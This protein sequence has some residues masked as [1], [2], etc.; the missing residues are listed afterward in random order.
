MLG[1]LL[2]PTIEELIRE[3][4]F[5]SL[6]EHLSTLQAADIAD[7]IED[8]HES[9][10]TV[11]F[12]LLPKEKATE[13]F[14]YLDRGQQQELLE[15][16]SREQVKGILEEMSVDDRTALLDEVPPEVASQLIELLP[17][18]DR[19]LA[20]TILNYP[21]G[22]VGRLITPDYVALSEEMTVAQ[23]LDRIRKFGKDMETVY[24]CYVI[25]SHRK[26]LGFIS[27]RKLV[28]S[29]LDALIGDLYETNFVH[30]RTDT[31]AEDAVDIFRRY[32]LIALPVLDSE[33]NM[34]GIVTFD[35]IMDVAEEE[36]REDM[37]RMAAVVP[38][39]SDAG[40]L[41]ESLLSLVKR[42]SP[43]LVML[44]A[45]Q[46]VAALILIRF[47]DLLESYTALLFFL[48]AL[49]A[50]GGNTGTQCSSMVI[51]AIATGEVSL[52][53]LKPVLRRAF[54]SGVMLAATLGACGFVISLVIRHDILVSLCVASGLAVVVLLSNMA[55][56]LLPMLFKRLGLD[57]A[58]M[59]G[60]FISTIT[61]IFG[62]FVYLEISRNILRLLG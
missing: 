24:A 11:L 37:D 9:H 51:R 62:L 20:Q 40:F 1:K 44:L 36:F 41:E 15:S 47:E 57:P 10:L 25:G 45:I 56:S 39:E 27:L 18:E 58:L 14:E 38:A 33:G 4:D 42:R 3:R 54:I 43:W 49:T 12:R 52:A 30:L 31:P 16:L 17:T 26:L 61:D 5:R 7:I 32:D 59:S 53:D 8:L 6:K 50:T 19:K 28:T 23:G 55:G 60:P 35:D 2:F 34:V 22:S 13:V 21:E 46:A 48:P 29:P